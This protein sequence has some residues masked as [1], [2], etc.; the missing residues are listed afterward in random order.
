MKEYSILDRQT[1]KAATAASVQVPSPRTTNNLLGKFPLD[2]DVLQNGV[3][4]DIDADG[5]L[6]VGGHDKSSGVS[7]TR[8]PSEMRRVDSAELKL[9]A[10]PQRRI[11]I[12]K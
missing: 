5:I 3:T 6:N 7:P 9:M 2:G 4:F 10:C 12:L 1:A 8:L 11:N